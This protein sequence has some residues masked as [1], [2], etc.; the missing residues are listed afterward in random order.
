[1]ILGA[2]T[3]TVFR[4]PP[5]KRNA[6][7]EYVEASEEDFTIQ[8]SVQPASPQVLQTLTEGERTRDPR[9]IY[10]T[11]DLRTG[12][13]HDQTLADQVEIDENRYEVRE[14]RQ[15]RALLAHF[16]VTVLRLKE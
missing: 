9:V 6:D 13:Q 2:E 1:M 8:G 16:Q 15:W 4:R 14:V 10:T 3:L 7:G 12:S 11:S 5:G